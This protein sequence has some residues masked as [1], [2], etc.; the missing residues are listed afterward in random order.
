M[1]GIESS[2][3]ENL[4]NDTALAYFGPVRSTCLSS[5]LAVCN[6]IDFTVSEGEPTSIVSDRPALSRKW[7]YG[8]Y[9][10]CVGQDLKDVNHEFALLDG[11]E[12]KLMDMTIYEYCR[13]KNKLSSTAMRHNR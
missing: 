13:L 12:N 5:L 3:R 8:R 11:A 4:L 2:R 9:C 1:R 10:N 7:R 6:R